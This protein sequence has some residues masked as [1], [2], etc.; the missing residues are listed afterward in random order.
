LYLASKLV[1][2][3][4]P[5]YQQ[6]IPKAEKTICRV[7][8]EREFFHN[9]IYR[10]ALVTNET[11][12]SVILKFSENRLEISASSAEYGESHESMAIAYEGEVVRLAFNPQFL[13][14]PLKA[15]SKDE[16]YFEFNNELT[17]GVIKTQEDFLCVIMP[18]QLGAKTKA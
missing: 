4:Y 16:I 11:S 10:A 17:P 2:G 13:L 1:E 7:K 15:L 18:V 5:N 14:D 3:P 12:N 8:I 6:V 9:C